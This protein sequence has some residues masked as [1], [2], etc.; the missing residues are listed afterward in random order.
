MDKQQK[1]ELQ[2]LSRAGANPS[3]PFTELCCHKLDDVWGNLLSCSNETLHGGVKLGP[4]R[5]L[6]GPSGTHFLDQYPPSLD[7]LPHKD[8]CHLGSTS[9]NTSFPPHV[10][11]AKTAPFP[12]WIPLKL[13]PVPLR[14]F[15][16]VSLDFTYLICFNKEHQPSGIVKM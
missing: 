2:W 12:S 10:L 1:S 14:S 16:Q 13:N 15:L 4:L 9:I 11:P 7:V 6:W 3:F 8:L 5:T